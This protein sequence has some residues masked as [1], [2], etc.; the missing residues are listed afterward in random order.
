MYRS[1]VLKAWVFFLP[2]A[3]VLG[4]VV[5]IFW[6]SGE[7][8]SPDKIISY[9]VHR[10]GVP[11]LYE[12]IYNQN[13]TAHKL[14]VL[15][16]RPWQTVLLGNSRLMQVR[17][18]FFIQPAEVFNAAG[19]VSNPFQ[20]RSLL[21]AMPHKPRWL[22]ISLDH[23]YFNPQWLA[24]QCSRG[25]LQDR[26]DTTVLARLNT[27]FKP[28]LTVIN[29]SWR[30]ALIAWWGGK[31]AYSALWHSFIQTDTLKWGLG[32]AMNQ[33]G[34]RA[35]GSFSYGQRQHL[36]VAEKISKDRADIRNRIARR[37]NRFN[38]TNG[39]YEPALRETARLLD[40]CHRHQIQVVGFVPGYNPWTCDTLN[41]IPDYAYLRE[42][43]PRL[44]PLF[45]KFGFRL[46]DTYDGRPYG[47][48][49]HEFFDSFHPSETA[50]ARY[51]IFLAHTD[52]SNTLK[53]CIAEQRLRQKLDT[54]YQPDYLF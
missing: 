46:V 13:F 28:A 15:C 27:R 39:L 21:E 12:S 1:F 41:T 14:G 24:T 11:V 26:V 52:S 10:T 20:F 19:A 30:E 16:E 44:L 23:F 35:D 17:D 4:F 45:Q 54:S 8:V 50:M 18:S 9:S 32:A 48:Q 37:T 29:N 40:Y 3:A 7:T 31:I 36:G 49:P 6:L 25:G 38:A 47:V 5:G 43:Y 34:F 51:F 53:A 2:Y 42:V 22:F 33:R